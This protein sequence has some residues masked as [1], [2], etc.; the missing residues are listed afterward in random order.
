MSSPDSR[1]AKSIDT[2]LRLCQEHRLPPYKSRRICDI[3]KIRLPNAALIAYGDIA[4]NGIP[5]LRETSS[6]SAVVTDWQDFAASARSSSKAIW[7][8]P[9]A[10]LPDRLFARRHITAAMHLWT[11][12]NSRKIF[13]PMCTA[14]T[15][16]G[17]SLDRAI[18]TRSAR[19][20]GNYRRRSAGRPEQFRALNRTDRYRRSRL[21]ERL[22]Q[23]LC[24]P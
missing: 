23:R 3:H 12:K 1:R 4:M 21:T 8:M 18:S 2:F 24:Y 5:Y 10:A 15:P 9:R 22:G 16:P 14:R 19:M 11:Y 6:S 20:N 7:E 13:S 17:A